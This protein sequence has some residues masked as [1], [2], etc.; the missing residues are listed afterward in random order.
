MSLDVRAWLEAEGFGEYAGLFDA[1][2]IDGDA[3]GLLTERHLAELGIPLGP[4][5]KLLGAIA[6]LGAAPGAERRRLTVMFVD[7]VGSTALSSRLDPEELRDLIR[8]YQQAVADEVARFQAYI[9][10]YFGDGAL[11]YFGY[12]QAHE[13]DAERAVRTALAIVR[14][15]GA[16]RSPGGEPLAVRIGIATGLVVVGDLIGAGAASERAVIGETPNIAARLQQL[17]AAGEIV[18]SA[19][20]RALTGNLFEWRDLGPQMMKG[21]QGPTAG[22]A[23]LAERAVETRFE[24]RRG[25]PLTT[26]VGRDPELA[27]LL[28]LWRD[29]T[30]GRGS[31]VIVSG[32]AGIGKS[33][34]LRALE[35]AIAS[36][37]HL[38]IVN[39]CS[40]YHT[41]SALHPMIE[42]ISRAAGIDPAAE[43]GD[44]LQRLETLLRDA[45]KAETALIA[46]LLRIDG[47][48]ARG[49][50]GLTPEQKR[51]R[52][53]DALFN[54]VA[55]ASLVQPVLWMLEDAHWA[56]PTSREVVAIC[57]E[58]VARLPIL[59]VIT[60]RSEL[61]ADFSPG[62]HVSRIRLGRLGREQVSAMVSQL[63]HGKKLPH[64]LMD[65][66]SAKT[67]GVPLFVEEL[68]KTVLQA[69]VLRETDDAFVLD[70][71]PRRLALPASLHDSMVARLDRHAPLKQLAQTASCI[72]REFS[73]EL[74]AK[75]CGVPPAALEHDLRRLEEAGLLFRR[76]AAH[77][78]HYV[79]KHALLRDAAYES[80][81][82]PRRQETHGRILAALD[83][84]PLGAPEVLAQHAME[85]GLPE[86]AI[87]YWQQAGAAAIARP[88]YR[89]AISHL[90]QALRAA[91]TLAGKHAAGDARQWQ[92]RCL[93][94]LLLL[95]Q[96][97]IPL[98]GYSHSDTIAVFSRAQQLI[99]VMGGAPH[100]FS[101][102]YAMW[103]AYYVRGEHA[104]A[105]AVARDMRRQCDGD[106]SAG[107]MLS[108][109]RVVGISQMIT[110]ELQAA[111]A[112]FEEAETLAYV[113]R[114]RTREQ[115][116]AVA[117]RFAADPDIATQFH[118]ALT[119][120]A[121]GNVGIAQE[122]ARQAVAA[123]RA[124]GHVHTLGHALTHGAIFAAALRDAEETRRM[125]AETIAFADE[126]DMELWRGYGS[127][128]HAY[129][130]ILAG[131][132]ASAVPLM[133]RGFGHLERTETGTMVPLYHA[134]Q[135]YALA[136]LGRF[137][138][139]AGEAA[140]V[141]RELSAGSG[142]YWWPEALRW[143]GEYRRLLPNAQR[144]EVE[145]ALGQAIALARS[146]GARAYE[147]GAVTSLA[148][149][150][151]GLGERD[152][153]LERL[154]PILAAFR[155]GIQVPF[156]QCA[157]QLV[158]T[159]RAAAAPSAGE[160]ASVGEA[161]RR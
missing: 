69:G 103:V 159:M 76:G 4:S 51:M 130:M 121:L 133:Q 156:V 55:R 131:E 87:G 27:T 13:D 146:Q 114:Q 86:K 126:H 1:H 21:L 88:A 161:E 152:R 84:T 117:Q 78:Q 68:T 123:A 59:V 100:R 137:E 80:L 48:Q 66:I 75:V 79:F 8:D 150:W 97:C 118:V 72:G 129:A 157:T 41:D 50:P 63:A 155:E 74:L 101:V 160:R 107:R 143:I 67:D 91:E 14:A 18:V 132:L 65:E 102:S 11:V 96:A 62:P 45:D 52:T 90:G 23:L 39:Q 119:H 138:E 151:S 83:G 127:S 40:P 20:T 140:A 98:L 43:P 57:I 99:D 36:E 38:R 10:R 17:A 32:E 89:E 53:F 124:M 56:D 82:R 148:G 71:P 34:L 115:R 122:L 6:R 116:M 77:E 44:Q 142:R 5:L 29:A 37:N 109:L 125:A 24:G 12:P 93:Q 94:L 95:G 105:L 147:L 111:L 7:L 3:L 61:A 81:L 25:E 19:E 33:R 113:V 49:E 108:A 141:Q 153:A 135:A 92:E 54:Q 149:Y 46:A 9:A 42:Q 58:R 139:A 60:A 2:R 154:V 15:V 47:A 136:S 144:G 158:D 22:F 128:L 110:G 26:L 35:A 104:K 31:A 70:G 28:R 106:G 85:A 134:A 120:W 30:L 112:T 64:S 16:Q 145:D 73:H